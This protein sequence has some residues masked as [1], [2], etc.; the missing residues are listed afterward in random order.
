MKPLFL[1]A[2]VA[3]LCALSHAEPV[4]PNLKVALCTGDFGM[5]AQDRVPMI[6]NA[7]AFNSP[8]AGV[9]W[10]VNQSYNMTRRLEDPIWLGRFDCV[11]IGD[12]GIGQLTPRAQSNLVAWVRRGGGLVWVNQAKSTI[13]FK[14]SEDAVPMPLKAILPVAYPDFSRP[15]PGAQVMASGDAFFKGID[16]SPLSAENA[17]KDLSQL[18]TERSVGRGRVLGLSGAFTK[19][20]KQV[21]YATYEDI[22]GS[23]AQFPALGEIWTRVLNRAS[24]NSPRRGQSMAQV[25][26]AFSPSILKATVSVDARQKIDEIR[27]GDFSVVALKQLYNEDGGAHEDLF[28]ALNPRDWFDRRSQELMPNTQG[29]KSDKP[30]FF[31]DYNIRGIYL[32][33]NT[34]GGYSNWDDAKYAEQ[35]ALAVEVARKYGALIPFFQAGNEPPLDAGY[36]KFHQRFVG[37]VLKLAPSYQVIGPNKAFNIYGVDPKE[38]QFY[39]DSCGKTTDILNWHTYGQPPSTILAEARYWSDR[40]T[41]KMRAPGPARVM[42]TENDA[43]NQG[44]SQF[45]YIMERALTFLPEKRIIANFQYCMEPRS[46]GGTYRFGVLQP[47]GEM[48]ANYN[49]YWIWKDLRGDMVKSSIRAALA[50]DNPLHVLASRSKDGRAVTAVV[51]LSTPV[52]APAQ[53][54]VGP[55]SPVRLLNRARANVEV[56]LPP[57]QWRLTQNRAA[58]NKR[59][60]TAAPQVFTGTAKVP[61]E[62]APY[63]AVALTWTRV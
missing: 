5:W 59:T 8:G 9:S 36:V 41:G 1:F 48:S 4:K 16:F 6:E 18:L 35:E 27:G 10:E 50:Q 28:L 32:A 34:Y 24:L 53:T 25:D 56:Q 31:R 52:Y 55:K 40:A 49:G 22:P 42:F 2:S 14:G 45:N 37:Q 38:M 11:V 58:W 12:V 33:D 19:E 29:T 3:S 7:V 61:V 39:I 30:A 54:K 13:P 60:T 23:W 63:E 21:A 26:A 20:T 46:E 51:Y 15:V 44:D 47:D 62:V 43:W 17:R 57:G